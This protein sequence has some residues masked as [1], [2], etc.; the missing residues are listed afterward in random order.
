MCFGVVGEYSGEYDL[1]ASLRYRWLSAGHR[2]VTMKYYPYR[3]L[4]YLAHVI[5]PSALCY[6]EVT[7]NSE[8]QLFIELFICYFIIV[9]TVL[10]DILTRNFKLITFTDDLRFKTVKKTFV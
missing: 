1:F 6:T 4:P 9:C 7:V 2:S 10:Y 5:F 3:L 8:F